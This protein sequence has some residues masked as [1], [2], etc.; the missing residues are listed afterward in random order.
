[1]A[2]DEAAEQKATTALQQQTKAD[3][4]KAQ[5]CV[6]VCIEGTRAN[7]KAAE[8]Q[9]EEQMNQLAS[10]MQFGS[11]TESPVELGDDTFSGPMS[12]I[13]IGEDESICEPVGISS[14][15]GG[16]CGQSVTDQILSDACGSESGRC[17]G[18]CKQRAEMIQ[19]SEA[20]CKTNMK[21]PVEAQIETAPMP[22]EDS[23]AVSDAARKLYEDAEKGTKETKVKTDQAKPV[24]IHIH[25]PKHV[26][27]TY[28][29]CAC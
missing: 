11:D 15:S 17:A 24:P 2:A 21:N 16:A 8:L 4:L 3:D 23:P 13:E 25:V 29:G 10:K 18:I 28:K 12:L 1:V 6:A 19:T 26:P 7:H 22:S 20:S 5:S 9:K 14:S 27:F